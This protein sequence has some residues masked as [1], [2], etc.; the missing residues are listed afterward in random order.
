MSLPPTSS[1]DSANGM[2]DPLT[3]AYSRALLHE[4]YQEEIE[5]ARRYGIPCSLCVFDLDYFK[6]VNDAY[7]HARGDAV[8]RELVQRIS[9]M[10]RTSDLLFRYGG[11]EFILLCPNT[12]KTDA[13]LLAQ[14]VLDSIQAT[15]F[16]G[17]ARLNVSLSIGV[18]SFPEDAQTSE[19]L[20]ES[21]D[22]RN[23]LAKRQGRAQ[24]V[25]TD[26]RPSD[27]VPQI[28]M[29][30]LIEQDEA[31]DR[32]YRFLDR[33]PSTRAGVLSVVG[34]A[35]SGRTRFLAKVAEAARL[36]GS[37]VIG[38]SGNAATQA[39]PYS[40][41]LD[42]G[43]VYDL[44]FPVN[45]N[46]IKAA[47]HRRL[48]DH[49]GMVFTVD[50]VADVDRATIAVLRQMLREVNDR[51]IA[52]VYPVDLGT[53]RR[54]FHIHA[55]L[56]EVVELQPLSEHGLRIWIRSL[57]HWEPPAD[58][59]SWLHSETA[60]LPKRF[61]A[62]LTYL[63]E[64]GI[65]EQTREHV[66]QIRRNYTS[67]ALSERLGVQLRLPPHN[68]PGT[69]TTCIGRERE[70]EQLTM[71]LDTNRLITLFGPGGVG[72]TR[73]ALQ[74]ANE[75]LEE[76]PDGV[77]WFSLEMI[78]TADAMLQAIAATFGLKEGAHQS[79]RDNLT[80]YL[81]DK[82]RLLVLDNFEQA[83]AAAPLVTELLRAAPHLKVI[84]TSRMILRVY[85]EH[86][87]HVS[88]L[89]LP[90]L[91]LASGG[92]PLAS[93]VL[94][95]PAIALFVAR[96]HAIHPDFALT[97]QNVRAVVELCRRLD[98]LPL[99]I[100][101]A[102]VHSDMLTPQ[103][104]VQQ[105][106]SR[107]SLLTDGP[108]DLPA[109]QQTL[110]NAIGWSYDLLSKSEQELFVQLAVFIGSFT[111]AAVQAVCRC[112][113]ACGVM[114]ELT[115][116]VDKSLLRIEQS[117]TGEL[118][119]VM[120]ETIREFAL[121]QLTIRAE[122]DAIRNRHA[123]FYMTCAEI[124][125]PH[126]MGSE[127]Q[128]WLNRLEADHYNLQ[129]AIRWAIEHNLT[130]VSLRLGAGMWRFWAMHS[131]AS[132]GR[133]WLEAALAARASPDLQH[134]RAKALVGLGTLAWS[135]G[136]Y[137]QALPP[138]TASVSALRVVN[139][140]ATLATALN[141]LGL[142]YREQ[143]DYDQAQQHFAESLTIRQTIGDERGTA[144][145]LG[146]LGRVAFYQNH[147]TEAAA[148]TTESLRIF[149]ELGDEWGVATALYDLAEVVLYR[150]DY[151]QAT[152]LLEEQ[153]RLSRALGD[154]ILVGYALC[155]LGEIA[156][157]QGQLAEAHRLMV[158]A[159]VLQQESG[160]KEGAVATIERLA[161]LS[162]SQGQIVQATRLW[163]AAQAH[164]MSIG[165]PFPIVYHGRHTTMMS[166]LQEGLD[167]EIFQQA[168]LDGQVMTWN[169]TLAEALGQPDTD[170]FWI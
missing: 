112:F 35:G 108:R 2:R 149:R 71:L 118:R 43:C 101:L 146:N 159:L 77:F 122:A 41:L 109:R 62:G 85:G 68:L 131:Y 123:T 55:P 64:Q 132:E 54:R 15:A 24:V 16:G 93:D 166:I 100:E 138:L 60:G 75:V 9:S 91:P 98:G 103:E 18:A 163:S 7:G 97:Q 139:D 3:G 89:G 50:N 157:F 142:V 140:S 1:S 124:A 88:P 145:T 95:Y 99:A 150:G 52:V 34:A 57:L 13:V 28:E 113:P 36:R 148:Y 26:T 121:E 6:S 96:T 125:E 10:L 5:R 82:R 53:T 72:K 92:L 130:A 66:W 84:V 11:D 8:L 79:L 83:I 129:A 135:Q 152:H 73:L 4:R 86:V 23:Y 104:M 19:A 12:A 59:L 45:V 110:R 63:L 161:E 38:L 162:V 156:Y 133:K 44:G 14:R 137:Q 167:A 143:G 21:A 25:S 17:E 90:Q 58:F 170:S 114:D 164:R 47:L 61:C 154:K 160:D 141:N 106:S 115:S 117:V 74:V 78:D 46:S 29:S 151:P 111:K 120:L 94:H 144:F 102:A 69:L 153:L 81:R 27:P 165:A 32:A 126:L 168:W 158:E 48:G 42:S 30:R 107:L 134:L 40:A 20:F 39:R 80:R 37:L 56:H 119:F 22:R 51:Y 105:I 65:L 87:F 31:L 128:Q 155:S 49:V 70:L 169:Q 116:L 67:I 136:D 33:V 147:I 127:Q 76:F